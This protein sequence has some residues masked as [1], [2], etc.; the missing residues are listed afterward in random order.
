[1]GVR[2]VGC[3]PC[4]MVQLRELKALVQWPEQWAEIR[5]RV[6]M[7]EA[8]IGTSFFPPNYIPKRFMTGR[9]DEGKIFPWGEDVFRYV[10]KT[11]E[12]QMP[13]LEQRSC[14]SVYNLCE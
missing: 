11:T 1:M 10:E 9:T 4:V 2:R 3:F 14:M 5:R 7:V 13:M 12:D 6:L 8:K